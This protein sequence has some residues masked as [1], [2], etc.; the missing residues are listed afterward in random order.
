MIRKNDRIRFIDEEKHKLHG[1][2]LVLEIKGYF[3]LVT[4]GNYESFGQ[5]PMTVPLSEIKLSE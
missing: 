4:S 1:I 2:L 5:S 3:A